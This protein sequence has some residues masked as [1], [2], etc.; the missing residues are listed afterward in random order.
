MEAAIALPL[1]LLFVLGLLDVGLW[2]FQTTQAAGAARDGSRAAIL[3]YQQAD[4]PTSADALA[5]RAAIERR[6]GSRPFGEPITV[7]VRCVGAGNLVTVT[8]GCAQASVVDRDR[9]EVT[10][11]WPRRALSFV[12]LAFGASQTVRGRAAMVVLGRP[13]GVDVAP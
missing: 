10:V 6:I 12:T 5:V 1:V 2:V 9:V 13:A 7:S 3:R 8:G 11:T 4:V